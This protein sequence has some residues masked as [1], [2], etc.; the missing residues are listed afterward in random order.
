MSARNARK[1][2]YSRKSGELSGFRFFDQEFP[3]EPK[4]YFYDWLYIKALSQNPGLA[5]TLTRFAGFT[6][7]EFNPKKSIN[8]QAYTAA[9][10]VSFVKQGLID[11]VLGSSE[12]FLQMAIE[13]YELAF[14]FSSAHSSENDLA[15]TLISFQV[16]RM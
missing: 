4:T 16:R 1:E 8:C 11:R 10:Y 9:L 7:I 5:K 6:D 2:V 3:L 12:A 15:S 13:A 14:K